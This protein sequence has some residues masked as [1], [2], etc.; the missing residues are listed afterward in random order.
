MTYAC[1]RMPQAW[2]NWGPPHSTDP[3]LTAGGWD[4]S[5]QLGLEEERSLRWKE[6]VKAADE[7]TGKEFTVILVPVQPPV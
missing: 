6:R 2:D 3:L 7:S 1:S 5:A 4:L